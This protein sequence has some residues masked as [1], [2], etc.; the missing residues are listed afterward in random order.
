LIERS[1]EKIKPMAPFAFIDQR[2]RSR[3]AVAFAASATDDLGGVAEDL[4]LT[5]QACIIARAAG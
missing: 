4:G 1:D 2:K 3:G 5:A